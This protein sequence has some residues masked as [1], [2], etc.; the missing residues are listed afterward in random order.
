M[1]FLVWIKFLF[2]F[3]KIWKFSVVLNITSEKYPKIAMSSSVGRVVLVRIVLGLGCLYVLFIHHDICQHI[4][5]VAQQ[6]V[7]Q[8]VCRRN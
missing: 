8:I 2:T 3:A 5:T 4:V 1:K 7:A 6:E